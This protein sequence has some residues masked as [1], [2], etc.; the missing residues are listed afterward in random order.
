MRSGQRGKSTLVAEV[1]N[2]SAN[3][4]WLLV[5]ERELSVPFKQFPWF[6]EASI[7]Q[8]VNVQ[9]LHRDHLHWLA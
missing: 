5:D 1:A 2:V 3:G 9:R 8:I 4:F 6:R 7:G